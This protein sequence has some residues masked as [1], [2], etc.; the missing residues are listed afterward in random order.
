MKKYGFGIIGLGM[1]AK[2]HVKAI[3]EMENAEFVAGFHPKEEKASAFCN[4]NGGKA[5]S[6]L[7][8]FLSDPTIDVVSIATPSGLHLEVAIAAL[9]AGKHVVVEKPLEVTKE[10]CFEIINVA[11]ECNKLVAGIFQSRYLEA[12]ALIKDAIEKG[13]FGTLAMADA[14][15]KWYRT[16]EYYDSGAWRGTWKIDGGGALMNQS[17]HGIDVLQYLMGEVTEVTAYTKTLA[18]ERIE[19]ED[20]ATAILKFKNGALGVIEGTTAAYP[21][22]SKKIEICGSKGSISLEEDNIV[23]WTFAEETPE[24]EKIRQ[25]FSNTESANAGASDPSTINFAGHQRVFEALVNSIENNLPLDIDGIEASKSV[26][27]IEAIYRSAKSGSAV[28]LPL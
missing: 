25:K 21:G 5:Y 8:E 2:Y 6:N 9:K 11:K 22:F 23:K 3:D 17:I 14:Q 27:L 26:E 20:T 1:I 12:V 15:V 13:R 4:E 24:D 7:D 16:Q 18:H 28:S 10:R 19:V